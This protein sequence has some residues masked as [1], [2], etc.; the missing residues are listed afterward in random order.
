ML[1]SGICCRGREGRSQGNCSVQEGNLC[2]HPFY[3]LLDGSQVYLAI[4][5]GGIDS[6]AISNMAFGIAKSV[7]FIKVSSFQG[8]KIRGV[9]L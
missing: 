5:L 4:G 3:I 2:V 1:F 8:V 7:L 9:P 6:A